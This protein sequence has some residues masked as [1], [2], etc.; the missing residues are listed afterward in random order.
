M[1]RRGTLCIVLA[2]ALLAAVAHSAPLRGDDSFDWRKEMPECI[3]PVRGA[4]NCTG[5]DVYL[6]TAAVLSDRFCISSN[7]TE[8]VQLSAQDILSCGQNYG[9]GGSDVDAA[10]DVTETG[11][12]NEAC[13]P[14]T[15][16]AAGQAVPCGAKCQNGKVY[17][18]D[19]KTYTR[20]TGV[21]GI[22]NLVRASGPA[23]G[24]MTL[25]IDMYNYKSGVYIH[26]PGAGPMGMEISLRIVGWGTA[27]DGTPFWIA[28]APFFGPAWGMGGYIWVRMGTDECGIES[29]GAY[30]IEPI[31]E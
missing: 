17:R 8:R 3:G 19:Y 26:S 12:V 5:G 2:A 30:A 13:F 23:E 1:A 27:D 14:Y 31:L 16:G 4:G 15:A 20:A 21:S 7:G 24:A 11:I 6:V 25:Y 28:S 10:F 18:A 22:Q 9:C 29:I